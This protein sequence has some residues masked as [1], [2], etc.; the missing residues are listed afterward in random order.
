[1]DHNPGNTYDEIPYQKLVHVQTHPNRIGAWGRLYGL[2]AKHANQCRVL[3]IGCAQGANLIPIARMFPASRYVGI[4]LSRRHIEEGS[5]LVKE[6]GLDNI[7]LVQG[8]FTELDTNLGRFDFI[9]AH[10]VFSYVGTDLQ[11]AMLNLVR[12]RLQPEGIAFI[13][14]NVY[15]GWHMR[16]ILRDFV[17]FITAESEPLKNR[18]ET[19]RKQ[20]DF[21]GRSFMDASHP[22]S[23][24]LRNE[25]TSLD[26]LSDSYI[27]H[28][29][30][31][32]S[33]QPL[34]FS[35][36][37]RLLQQAGL[38]YLGDAQFGRYIH[39]H[40]PADTQ[41]KL[42]DITEDPIALEQYG[43]YL[44]HRM[45]RNSMICRDDRQLRTQPSHDA[46]LE[47][48]VGTEIRSTEENPA[49][50]G[51]AVLEFVLGNT[52]LRVE[53]PLEKAICITL[54]DLFPRTIAYRNFEAR[55]VYLL[56]EAGI[57]VDEGKIEEL[58]AHVLFLHSSELI[59]LSTT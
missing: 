3:E 6:E 47:L 16:G 14:L 19:S 43:D 46:L 54:S 30:L 35:E 50:D 40:L 53:D 24:G 31:E 26:N 59:Y 25:I 10:G 38:Q 37:A 45:F 52:P 29:F 17:H 13:S 32:G 51:A 55:A 49:I 42:L 15:P 57:E 36:Y 18:I 56:K 39:H 34:Y 27:G 5:A 28:E 2:N 1:M 11:E 58:R 41:E 8:S 4:D 21:L 9:I 48:Q 7:K 44:V 22:L 23:I 12:E 20:L 33:N